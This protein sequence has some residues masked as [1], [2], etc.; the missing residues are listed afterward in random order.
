MGTEKAWGTGR[1]PVPP[2]AWVFGLALVVAVVVN[3]VVQPIFA[4]TTPNVTVTASSSTE[5]GALDLRRVE[6]PVGRQPDGHHY[7]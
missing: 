6:H 2:V 3:A 7:L 4:A 1:R 5:G